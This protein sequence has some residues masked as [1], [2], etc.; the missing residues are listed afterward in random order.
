MHALT[1]QVD[2]WW[3]CPACDTHWYGQPACWCCGEANRLAM[4]TPPQING[5]SCAATITKPHWSTQP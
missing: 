4:N 2:R 5:A 1:V 3:G